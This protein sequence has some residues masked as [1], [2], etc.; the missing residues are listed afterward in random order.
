MV[1]HALRKKCHGGRLLIEDEMEDVEGRSG[2]SAGREVSLCAR[3][4]A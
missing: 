3:N 4:G 2:G 1:Q